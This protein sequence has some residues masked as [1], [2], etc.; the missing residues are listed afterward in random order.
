MIEA[1]IEM[2]TF[3]GMRAQQHLAALPHIE[4]IINTTNFYYLVQL[5]VDTRTV[6]AELVQVQWHHLSTSSG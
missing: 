3:E 5:S 1:G 2:P 6:R 4:L